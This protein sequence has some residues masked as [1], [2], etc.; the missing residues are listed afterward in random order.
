MPVLPARA[1][2]GLDDDVVRA[3]IMANGDD[4]AAG[5]RRRASKPK[6]RTGCITW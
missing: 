5:K 4:D 3:G 2:R 6:V 1:H